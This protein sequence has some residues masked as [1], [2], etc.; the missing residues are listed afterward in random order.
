MNYVLISLVAF[1]L[2]LKCG[3]VKNYVHDLRMEKKLNV[4]L[5]LREDKDSE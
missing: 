2:G 3:D 4:L 1:F 5:M